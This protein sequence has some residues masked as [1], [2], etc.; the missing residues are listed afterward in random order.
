MSYA[1]LFSMISNFDQLS[2]IGMTLMV[3]MSIIHIQ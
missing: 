3:Y 1:R 2:D